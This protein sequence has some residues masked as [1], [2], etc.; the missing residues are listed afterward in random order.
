[1]DEEVWISATLVENIS[2]PL[3]TGSVKE[4][5]PLKPLTQPVNELVVIPV[6]V[7]ISSSILNNPYSFGKPF[8]DETLI[9]VFAVV[10]PDVSVVTPTMTSGV[11]L[12][13][14]R[15][16]SKLSLISKT[17]PRCSWEI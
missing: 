9:V 11:R 10:I 14:L 1:M 17:P 6:Y 15:Y 8:V 16:W 7:I 3:L 5:I 12:S 2:S 13:S 4:V